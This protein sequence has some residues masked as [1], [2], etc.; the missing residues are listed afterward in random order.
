MSNR[1]TRIVE[2]PSGGKA[3]IVTKYTFDEYM[4]IE[5]HELRRAK[6]IDIA[7]QTVNLDYDTP[8]ATALEAMVQA[9]KKL[10]NAAGEELPV[11]VATFAEMEVMDG[12]TLRDAVNEIQTTSKKA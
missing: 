7:T 10:T 9:T 3:E 12:I 1:E 8:R 11:N 2:L 5:S 4:K 6:S